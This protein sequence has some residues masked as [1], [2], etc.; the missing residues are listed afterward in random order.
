MSIGNCLDY[1]QE[2]IDMQNPKKK[3]KRK[4]TQ[5]DFDNF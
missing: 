1:V 2:W 5:A 4:A 3:R